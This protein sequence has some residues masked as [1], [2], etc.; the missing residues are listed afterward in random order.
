MTADDRAR[1]HLAYLARKAR[2]ASGLSDDA[3]AVAYGLPPET[4]RDWEN[5]H[6]GGTVGG[7]PATLA[8]LRVIAAMPEAVANIIRAA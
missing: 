6:H 7:D 8:Y 1:G 4:V 5:G 2:R 3:F